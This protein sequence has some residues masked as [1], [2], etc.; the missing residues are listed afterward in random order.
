MINIGNKFIHIENLEPRNGKLAYTVV[1]SKSGQRIGTV[2]WYRYW[3]RY[4]LIPLQDTV[5]D[6]GCM[7]SI[8]KFIGNIKGR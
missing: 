5:W 4:V 7:E 8:I 2:E 6:V 1:N 3:G